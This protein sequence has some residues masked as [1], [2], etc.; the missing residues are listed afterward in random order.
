M[1]PTLKTNAVEILQKE[2]PESDILFSHSVR[3]GLILQKIGLGE[4]IISAGLLHHV[5]IEKIEDDD[6]KTIVKKANQLKELTE[7]KKTPKARP[8]KGSKRSLF[9]RQAENL[10]RMFFAI[11]R[12][13]RPIFVTLAGRLDT[14]RNIAPNISKEEQR[15]AGIIAFEILAPLAYGLGMGEMK[16][17]FEDLAFPYVYPK[18]YKFILEKVADKHQERKWYMKEVKKITTNLLTKENIPF[19]KVH[20]RSKYYFSLYQKMMRYNLDAEEI[21]DFVALRIVMPDIESCYKTLGIIHKN[22]TPVSGRI[23][24]YISTPKA[25]GYRSLHTTIICEQGKIV[26]FQIRTQE[27]H[28]E[29]EYGAAAHLSYA[30]NISHKKYTHKFYWIE[31]IRRLREETQNAKEI[32]DYVGSELF[33]DKIFV[34]TPNGEIIS[35]SKDSTPVDFAYAIHTQVGDRCEGAKINDKMKGLSQKLK[36]GDTVEILTGKNKTPSLD[37]LRFVKTHRAKQKIKNF[38]EQEH[39]I[40]FKEVKKQSSIIRSK[41]EAI[42]KILPIKKK[43]PQ[44]LIGGELG[45]QAKLSKCCK[46]KTT[47]TLQ[48]FITNGEGASVHRAS[49]KNL[50]ELSE[51]WPQRIVEASWHTNTEK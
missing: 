23:K 15:K 25:N 22:W 7:L 27:M 36:T 51:K 33:K 48:A 11:S 21:Y 19:L 42:K 24:D 50:K 6:I 46:P 40:N 29:A 3:T 26:E 30:K 31:Q 32:S 16:G 13:L 8:I 34:F 37:W 45:I 17:Q 39:G 2:I 49:C 47:D 5:S 38:L 35:L 1:T 18:E 43:G 28:Q 10:R 44:I 12:D 4:K 20:A 9:D 41:V 14:M